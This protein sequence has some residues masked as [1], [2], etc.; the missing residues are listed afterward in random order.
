MTFPDVQEI[1]SSPVMQ[2]VIQS[3]T[4]N[5]PEVRTYDPVTGK[6]IRRTNALSCEQSQNTSLTLSGLEEDLNLRYLYCSM[7]CVSY[8]FLWF[9]VIQT[10]TVVDIFIEYIVNA[11]LNV[12]L[13][14][15]S[16]QMSVTSHSNNTCRDIKL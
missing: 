15:N 10:F 1:F 14:W 2:H 13:T 8:L 3:K 4:Y 11:I 9:I 16:H 12:L 5:A 6:L 7:D